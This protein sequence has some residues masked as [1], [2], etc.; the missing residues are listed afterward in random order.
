MI[1]SLPKRKP[2][3]VDEYIKA[4]PKVAQKKLREMRSI[5]KKASPR[6]QEAVKWGCP[7]FEEKR[8]LYAYAAYKAHMG[9]MPTPAVIRAFKKDLE[10]FKTGKGSIQFPY[11][12]PLPKALIKKIAARRIKDLKEKDARWM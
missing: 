8:I 5:L 6:A 1:E 4:A 3:T 9:L 10:K 2:K 7:V 11:D 12:K